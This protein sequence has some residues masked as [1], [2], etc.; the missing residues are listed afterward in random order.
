MVAVH[1]QRHPELSE[2]LPRDGR[3]ATLRLKLRHEFFLANDVR[4]AFR[5][6]S[7]GSDQVCS[8]VGHTCL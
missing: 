4:F 7:L 6:M 1:L 8:G 5:D 3:I 2:Q